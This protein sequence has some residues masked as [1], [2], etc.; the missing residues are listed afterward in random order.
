MVT[1]LVLGPHRARQ[2]GDVVELQFD[3]P[4]TLD[5]AKALHEHLAA[6]YA[7]LGSCFVLV[8]LGGVSAMGPESRRY[9][10]EW[11]R[12]HELSGVALFGGNFAMRAIATL[13]VNAIHLLSNHRTEIV[14]FRDEAD[15]RRWIST[16][17]D[18]NRDANRD[19]SRG[20]A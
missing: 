5:Q 19:A 9:M 10:G 16:R 13:T 7:E 6:S 18:A 15:A 17:R 8:D 20:P 14:F 11:H 2:V 1:P 12:S 4:L 3:G